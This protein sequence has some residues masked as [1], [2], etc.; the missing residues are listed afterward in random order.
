MAIIMHLVDILHPQLVDAEDLVL[1]VMRVKLV[2]VPDRLDIHIIQTEVGAHV[3]GTIKVA[4]R[5]A[6]TLILLV[7]VIEGGEDVAPLLALLK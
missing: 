4:K 7:S 5:V 1:L 3:V 2:D 6:L